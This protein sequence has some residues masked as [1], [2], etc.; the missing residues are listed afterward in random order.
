MPSLFMAAGPAA[1]A[2]AE[3]TLVSARS[4]AMSSANSAVIL[5]LIL[6]AATPL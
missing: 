4:L 6:H 2:A 1:W 3:V 5:F